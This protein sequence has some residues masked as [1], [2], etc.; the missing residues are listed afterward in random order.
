M[1]CF[2]GKAIRLQSTTEEP[3]AGYIEADRK[4]IIWDG[5]KHHRLLIPGIQG[6]HLRWCYC[7]GDVCHGLILSA[8]GDDYSADNSD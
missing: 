1:R 3:F 6:V 7:L 5:V 8:R 4:L 2:D